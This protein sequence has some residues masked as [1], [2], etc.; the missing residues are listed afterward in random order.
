LSEGEFEVGFR[1]PCS[2][3]HSDDVAISYWLL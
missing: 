3:D 1:G 2:H